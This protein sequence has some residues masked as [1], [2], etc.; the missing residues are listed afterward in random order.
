MAKWRGIGLKNEYG[1]TRFLTKSLEQKRLGFIEMRSKR[2]KSK[3][4]KNTIK[5]RDIYL[6]YPHK[7]Q[8]IY[9]GNTIPVPY[10]KKS[11]I[12]CDNKYSLKYPEWRSIVESYLDMLGD[13]LLAGEF[14]PLPYRMGSLTIRKVKYVKKSFRTTSDNGRERVYYRNPHT[15]GY[16]PFLRWDRNMVGSKLRNRRLFKI[17]PL[18]TYKHKMNKYINEDFNRI[19]LYDG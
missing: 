18:K 4:K 9:I 17:R 5:L 8:D 1:D 19:F 12:D 10:V 7:C 13:F 16:M 2:R 15:Q 6:L 14:Y 3:I 11:E